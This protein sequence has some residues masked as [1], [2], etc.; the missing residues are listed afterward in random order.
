MSFKSFLS[1]CVKMKCSLRMKMGTFCVW[2]LLFCQSW[3]GNESRTQQEPAKIPSDKILCVPGHLVRIDPS[4][5]MARKRTPCVPNVYPL[6]DARHITQSFFFFEFHAGQSNI[7]INILKPHTNKNWQTGCS[8]ISTAVI[9]EVCESSSA[10][11]PCEYN[12]QVNLH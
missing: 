12:C 8:W 2:I 1:H 4:K 11:C 3:G 6:V 9:V 10:H 5:S 7:R